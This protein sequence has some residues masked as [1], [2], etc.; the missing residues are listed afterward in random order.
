[1]DRVLQFF[2]NMD[3]GI[4]WNIYSMLFG[5]VSGI[6]TGYVYYALGKR[7]KN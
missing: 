4:K 7:E 5:F 3:V 2:V 6:I 1:M